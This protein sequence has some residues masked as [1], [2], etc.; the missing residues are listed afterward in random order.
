MAMDGRYAEIAGANFGDGQGWPMRRNESLV[1]LSLEDQTE[2]VRR[3][4]DDLG[5]RKSSAMR[6]VGHRLQV[7]ETPL[8]IVRPQVKIELR[9][10]FRTVATLAAVR[11][12]QH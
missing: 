4:V 10:A 5:Q 12:V 8:R 6:N 11:P 1:F 9:I 3:H 2:I 7:A